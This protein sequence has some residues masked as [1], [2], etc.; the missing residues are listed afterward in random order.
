MSSRKNQ[1]VQKNP[2]YD[3][4][5]KKQNKGKNFFILLCLCIAFPSYFIL[6]NISLFIGI[7]HHVLLFDIY[8]YIKIF[9]WFFKI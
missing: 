7:G 3:Y 6:F 2:K 9:N 5:K 4:M 8:I 1:D